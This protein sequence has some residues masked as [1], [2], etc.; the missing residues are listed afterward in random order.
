MRRNVAER[1]SRRDLLAVARAAGADVDE[2]TSR[3]RLLEVVES[4]PEASGDGRFRRSRENHKWTE[5]EVQILQGHPDWTAEQVAR[6][7]GVTVGSVEYARKRYGRY[8]P[9]DAAGLCV[10]CDARP[11]YV[12]SPEARRLKLCKGC[13]QA[14]QRR[15]LEE[16][17][18][19]VRLRQAKKRARDG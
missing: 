15:R 2:A 19:A 12:E 7:M 11:V 9:K 3:A 16:E 8:A 6:S 17:P 4:L 14:E 1:L 13:W 10:V 18:E 5:E